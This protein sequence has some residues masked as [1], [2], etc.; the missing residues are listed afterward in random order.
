MKKLIGF[1]SVIL[2]VVLFA[3]GCSMF[4]GMSKAH[5]ES[6]ATMVIIKTSPEKISAAIEKVVPKV[7]YVINKTENTLN[8]GTYEGEGIKITYKKDADTQVKLYVRIGFAG[9]KDKENALIA[10]IKKD[11]GIN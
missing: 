9:D 10:D 2:T 7:G 1:A 4:D 6:K 3:A 11:L 5:H 8:S